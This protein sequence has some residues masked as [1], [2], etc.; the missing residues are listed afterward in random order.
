MLLQELPPDGRSG[1]LRI[2]PFGEPVLEGKNGTTGV[3][4]DHSPLNKYYA[5]GIRNGFG[6]AFDP[7][8][9]K[10]LGYRK[11]TWIW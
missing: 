11:W 7:V 1:I 8:T 9:S 3:L 4:A 2:T 5:F 10:A 6:I